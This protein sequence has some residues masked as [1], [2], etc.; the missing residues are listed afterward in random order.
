MVEAQVMVICGLIAVG[1]FCAML[2]I[3]GYALTHEPRE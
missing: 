2:A 3:V 1:S